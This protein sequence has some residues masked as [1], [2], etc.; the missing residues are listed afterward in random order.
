[1]FSVPDGRAANQP[2]AATTLSPPIAA[3]LPGARVSLAVIG[4]PARSD[5]LTAAGIELL[6][7]RLLFGRR[8]RVDPRVVRRAEPLGQLAVML[9]RVFARAGEDFRGQ[10]VENRSIFIGG[11][12]GAIPPQEAGACALFAAETKRP[13]EQTRARTT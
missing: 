5:A 6:K 8:R 12:D 2:L 13:V 10:Q 11:P 3:L 7:P 4:S 9:A 1:M